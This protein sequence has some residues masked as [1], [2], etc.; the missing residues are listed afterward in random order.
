M[1]SEDVGDGITFLADDEEALVDHRSV[2]P[3]PVK[4]EVD[5][6]GRG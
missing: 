6:L 3:S 5:G 2:V 1:L 4:F